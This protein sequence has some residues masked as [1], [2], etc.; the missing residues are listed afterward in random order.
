MLKTPFFLYRK[1]TYKAMQMGGYAHS[2]AKSVG[3]GAGVDNSKKGTSQKDV[4][5]PVFKNKQHF[6]D[7]HLC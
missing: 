4:W 5:G 3:A 6:V 2:S 7:M 1:A